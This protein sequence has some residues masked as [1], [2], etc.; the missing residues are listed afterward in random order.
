M[1]PGATFLL[2]LLAVLAGNAITLLALSYGPAGEGLV[3]ADVGWTKN[4]SSHPFHF[5]AGPIAFGGF[6]W[7]CAPVDGQPVVIRP[8]WAWEPGLPDAWE[9]W[10]HWLAAH[11]E[12]GADAARRAAGDLGR[13]DWS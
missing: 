8:M 5:V 6:G 1:K 11:P 9:R 13:A 4:D 3:F 10:R 12:Y 7:R 2:M